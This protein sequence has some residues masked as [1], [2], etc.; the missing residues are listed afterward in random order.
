MYR[1]TRWSIPISVV[2]VVF[3]LGLVHATY[4]GHYPFTGLAR[5]GWYSAYSALLVIGAFA[6]GL[7]DV[8]PG[9][10]PLWHAIGAVVIGAGG[11]SVIQLGVATPVLP[12][13][14]V[15]FA[16]LS[17]VLVFT[18]INRLSE[19]LLHH[20]A[21]RDR[22]VAIVDGDPERSRLCQEV[23]QV[24][25]R[26]LTLA[27]TSTRAELEAAE[28]PSPLLDLAHRSGATVVVL[29][30]A[31][32]ESPEIIAQASALHAEGIRIR[33]LSLFYDQ[34][35]GKLPVNELERISLL[36]DINE[37]HSVR[38]ARA[39]RLVDAILAVAGLAALAVAVPIVWTANL[40]GNRGPLLYRQERVGKHGATFTI[41]KFRT[42]TPD[43]G[44]DGTRTGGADG[45]S[46]G[47]G[48]GDSRGGADED[49]R[50]GG[51]WTQPGDARLTPVGRFLRRVHLDEL[52][53]VV[54]VL[55]G[56]L[57]VVG[58]RPEQPRYVAELE[59]TVPFYNVRHLV[60]PGMTGWAQVKYSYGASALDALEK[61]QYDFYYL[62]HQSLA[63]D[64]KILGRTVS[65][66]LHRSGR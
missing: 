37:L 16:G 35:L 55:R 39:K 32:Q 48:D 63:L 14:V 31:A 51:A 25:E 33:T 5:Y 41:V 43:P 58:P 57:T 7:P 56:E 11:M 30:R 27:A 62:R 22:V 19:R 59:Q 45:D 12:R 17:L 46:R 36:F 29:D 15:L 24:P 13:F 34:W 40:A 28:T 60:L 4:V 3:G 65:A 18:A 50:G 23:A 2:V 54:N 21:G 64:M 9:G 26:A 10:S 53:Q 49:S 6:V 20:L 44:A 1:L 38:Y 52:P 61:L 8:E 47:G 66:V 42:M